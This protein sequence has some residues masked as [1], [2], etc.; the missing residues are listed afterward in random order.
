VLE[1]K[2][3]VLKKGIA[4]FAA[5]KQY[6]KES[7][8][9]ELLLQTKPNLTINDYFGA[10]IANYRAKDYS[11]SYGIFD[12]VSQKFPDQEF[13]WEWKL[14]NATVLDSVKMDSI[15]LP[16]A[17]KL[18]EFAKKDTVKYAKQIVKASNFIAVYYNE[19][20]EKQKAVQYLQ[21]MK[22]ATS[23]PAQKELIEDNIKKLLAPTPQRQTRPATKPAGGASGTK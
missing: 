5:R 21:I 16:D 3:D 10:G 22:N 23:D 13:G 15:A 18:L 14:N 12:T 11:T 8:L 7:V 6:D 19:K 2:L 9:Q 20:N 4:F 1:N 17:M